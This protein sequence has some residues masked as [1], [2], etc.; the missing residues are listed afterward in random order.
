MYKIKAKKELLRFLNRII[1]VIV[2]RNIRPIE[3]DRTR[4]IRYRQT[5]GPTLIVEKFLF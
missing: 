3:I 4:T 1:K 2:T 5:Y